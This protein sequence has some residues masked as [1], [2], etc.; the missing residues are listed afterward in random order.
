MEEA[1]KYLLSLAGDSQSLLVLLRRGDWPVHNTAPAAADAEVSL[2]GIKGDIAAE[3]DAAVQLTGLEFRDFSP[4]V[5]AELRQRLHARCPDTGNPLWLQQAI[6]SNT[7]VDCR[8]QRET[9]TAFQ[10]HEEEAPKRQCAES[11]TAS[12][13]CPPMRPSFFPLLPSGA[14][15]TA[16]AAATGCTE[17]AA[18]TE[19]AA[20]R[21]LPLRIF[22]CVLSL[23]PH[24]QLLLA[25]LPLRMFATSAAT[26]SRVYPMLPRELSEDVCS[27]LPGV[28]RL[29]RSVF[30]RIADDG[31]ILQ[32]GETGT[33]IQS[34]A[35][36]TYSQVDEFL[37]SL[38]SCMLGRHSR[39]LLQQ[40]LQQ[41]PPHMS[42]LV[43]PE[44]LRLLSASNLQQLV[45]AQQQ[46]PSADGS[47]ALLQVLL[48]QLE[49]QH[50]QRA[51]FS[52]MEVADVIGI[53]REEGAR[54]G[55]PGVLLWRLLC[56]GS[57]G[58]SLT[59][60][61]PAGRFTTGGVAEDLLLLHHL[62]A[63]RCALRSEN[64]SLTLNSSVGWSITFERL[65]SSSTSPSRRPLRLRVIR[66]DK[67]WAHAMIEEA[68]VLANHVVA[69]RIVS[70]SRSAAAAT[71]TAPAHAGAIRAEKGPLAGQFDAEVSQEEQQ[72]QAGDTASV[73]AAT[74]SSPMVFGGVPSRDPSSVTARENDAMRPVHTNNAKTSPTF[75]A[76]AAA[77]DVTA[78]ALAREA[79]NR[80]DDASC[81]SSSE[82]FTPGLGE[83]LSFCSSR[84]SHQAFGALC[85]ACLKE[86]LPA[87]YIP[88]HSVVAQP[89]AGPFAAATAAQ[90]LGSSSTCSDSLNA[91][92][93]ASGGVSSSYAVGASPAFKPLSAAHW[94]LALP[95][96]LHFTSPIRRYAD[97]MVH[98][99]LKTRS[100]MEPLVD[101]EVVLFRLLAVVSLVAFSSICTLMNV[102][103]C[104]A[105]ARVSM[106][107]WLCAAALISVSTGSPPFTS[108]R[109]DACPTGRFVP[110]I[111]CTSLLQAICHHCNR[112]KRR[113]ED[114][115]LSFSSWYLN[116][117]LKAAHP[118]GLAYGYASIAHIHVPS[119]W[120]IDTP[121]AAAVALP[122]VGHR[123]ASATTK[124]SSATTKGSSATTDAHHDDGVKEA[125]EA[126]VSGG[127]EDAR[128]RASVPVALVS[129]TASEEDTPT[130]PALQLFVPLLHQARSYSLS[131]LGLELLSCNE[132]HADLRDPAT[133]LADENSGRATAPAAVGGDDCIRSIRVRRLP[134]CAVAARP[135]E[136]ER[137]E[138]SQQQ[139]PPHQ[140]TPAV[141]VDEAT[142]QLLRGPAGPLS[143]VPFGGEAVL[144]LFGNI[145]VLLVPGERQWALRLSF[146]P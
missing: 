2:I 49:Q 143:G 23:L 7:R 140:R 135:E 41:L 63:N 72:Q 8:Q 47:R 31:S 92:C 104:S 51:A 45:G 98:R 11:S 93:E 116:E 34:G 32:A 52:L 15:A 10:R 60:K 83:L 128:R 55:I 68:M 18:A 87:E 110:D 118:G 71:T 13:A 90:T 91:A 129:A 97:I 123:E 6:E 126:S 139:Q 130:Q 24:Q 86:L 29:A 112:N 106:P 88:S 121:A 124:G 100:R 4:A 102:A 146:D 22:S 53:I 127:S 54:H 101:L 57:F 79:N 12:S 78:S 25:W 108:T 145:R 44:L 142:A 95:V 64:G 17:A 114:A 20:C 67:R 84:M 125:K 138:V 109:L 65:E 58:A 74:A 141:P 96:Y 103:A 77:T 66:E 28:P 134:S 61:E 133:A 48:Q 16:D 39:L 76:A 38:C 62:A 46:Q 122:Q 19:A 9:R 14:S 42:P 131:T 26:D 80:Q 144:H 59:L 82:S 75:A 36:L 27:L 50:L 5:Y 56:C 81:A 117:Y 113:A 99:I 115:Q 107:F 137:T 136:K 85:F 119:N 3:A 111:M 70:E 33:L 105:F 94:G 73:S 1:A 40:Q 30:S 35:R 89:T 69:A 132:G 37:E 120:G 21:L 43:S